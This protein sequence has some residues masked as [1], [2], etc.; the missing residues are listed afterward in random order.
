MVLDDAY[1][2]DSS[3]SEETCSAVLE[4]HPELAFEAP[5]PLA[6]VVELGTVCSS[7]EKRTIRMGRGDALFD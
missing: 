3:W 1:C 5:L 6:E 4:L 7:I 2:V